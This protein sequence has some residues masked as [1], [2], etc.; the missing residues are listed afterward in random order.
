MRCVFRRSSPS[1]LQPYGC[2]KLKIPSVRPA[3]RAAPVRPICS[4]AWF[5]QPTVLR[6]HTSLRVPTAPLRRR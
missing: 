3:N 6:I 5:T 4:A 2:E 1:W